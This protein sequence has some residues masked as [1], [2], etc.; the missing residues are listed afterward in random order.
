V[1]KRKS[2]VIEITGICRA[3]AEGAFAELQRLGETI[4]HRVSVQASGLSRIPTHVQAYDGR[5][6]LVRLG[7]AVGPISAMG[8]ALGQ[9]VFTVHILALHTLG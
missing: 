8:E 9:P 4:S 7:N 3:A 2:V 5:A 6:A 1:I